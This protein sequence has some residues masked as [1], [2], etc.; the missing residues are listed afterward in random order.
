MPSEKFS[1]LKKNAARI[2]S[3]LGS[4]YV[5]EPMFS[6]IKHMKS[7]NRSISD[8]HLEHFLRLATTSLAA[9]TDLLV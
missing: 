5:N 9:D 3:L 2:I 6:R 4:T 7:K 1:K 8:S